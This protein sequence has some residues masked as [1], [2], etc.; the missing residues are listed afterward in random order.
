MAYCTVTGSF[1]VR[2]R[3]DGIVWLVTYQTILV[4]FDASDTGYTVSGSNVSPSPDKA[5]NASS[6]ERYPNVPTERRRSVEAVKTHL[7][8]SLGLGNWADE[9][10]ER[11]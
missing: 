6:G 3:A 4:W 2:R 8:M 11:S 7:T 1:A 10:S 5:G 9:Y